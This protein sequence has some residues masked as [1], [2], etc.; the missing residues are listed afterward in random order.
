MKLIFLFKILTITLFIASCSSDTTKIDV[1][2]IDLEIK[3]QRLELDLFSDIDKQLTYSDFE[4]IKKEY[5]SFFKLFLENIIAVGRVE[6]SSTVYYLNNFR[7]DLQ[8]KEV[9]QFT[10]QYYPDLELLNTEFTDAFKRYKK[11]FPDGIVP[12]VYSYVSGFSYPMVVDDSLLGIGL[13]MYLGR[14]ND[15]YR[16]LGIPVYKSRNLNKENIV[17]DGMLSWLTT[18][19][20]LKS[21][22]SNLLSHMIYHG[23]L[24]YALDLLLPNVPD[25]IKI[26]YSSDEIRWIGENEKNIWFHLAENDLLFQK[27]GKQ[28]QKYIGEGP[29]TPGFPEG[30][31][32]RAGRWIGW[33]IVRK[34]MNVTNPIDLTALFNQS[35]AQNILTKSKYKPS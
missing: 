18:E 33:Q 26:G 4:K 14:D 11:L 7:N 31:P 29:F 19:F 35:D 8:I 16:L 3:I 28:I 5:G 20:E 6:D 24:L 27:E 2:D 1:S 32:G 23:K 34:Y 25:S 15:Y 30:S 9:A 12:S 13:D 21:E 17:S 22:N 10:L